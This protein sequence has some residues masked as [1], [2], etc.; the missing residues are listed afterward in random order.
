MAATA[1]ATANEIR[2]LKAQYDSRNTNRCSLT[3]VLANEIGHLG[4]LD[5]RLPH[6][7]LDKQNCQP[8]PNQNGNPQETIRS[9]LLHG[10]PSSK[11]Q[12]SQYFHAST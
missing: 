3:R 12:T 6:E 10:I 8:V 2:T 5:G 1:N 11:E 4:D 9:Y 7:R